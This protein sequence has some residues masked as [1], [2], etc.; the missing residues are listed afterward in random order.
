MALPDVGRRIGD[1]SLGGIGN[2]LPEDT[3]VLRLVPDVGPLVHG[4]HELDAPIEEVVH[5]LSSR[6]LHGV[7]A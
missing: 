2:I 6:L 4:N 7:E 3:P 1:V 5:G